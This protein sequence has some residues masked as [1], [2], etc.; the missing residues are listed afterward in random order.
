MAEAARLLGIGER[1]MRTLCHDGRI[2]V[3]R[4]GRR[5]LVTRAALEHLLAEG[6]V[7]ALTSARQAE[8]PLRV[9]R[10]MQRR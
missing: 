8:T 4:L 7:T 2:P 6:E 3:L 1:H 5:V 10:A 9:V